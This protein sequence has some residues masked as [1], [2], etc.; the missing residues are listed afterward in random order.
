M[1]TETKAKPAAKPSAKPAAKPSAK[2]AAKPSAKPAA[3][4]KAAKAKKSETPPVGIH[5]PVMGLAIARELAPAKAN[6]ATGS[7]GEQDHLRVSASE[8]R[9]ISS[10]AEMVVYFQGQ[11]DR[12]QFS[13]PL[14]WARTY[15][16]AAARGEFET[17]HITRRNGQVILE[18]LDSAG[19][20]KGSFAHADVTIDY[21]NARQATAKRMAGFEFGGA[22]AY[23]SRLLAMLAHHRGRVG[24][25]GPIIFIS[26]LSPASPTLF[27][28]QGDGHE[29]LVG[30]QASPISEA[31]MQLARKASLLCPTWEAPEPVSGPTKTIP[32]LVEECRKAVEDGDKTAWDKLSRQ[33][34][35]R[36]G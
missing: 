26:G 17:L 14:A 9:G 8:V 25:H 2:P 15:F 31:D 24:G 29:A 35:A 34:Q 13:V 30:S 33:L 12:Q 20:V 10:K 11:G 3:K 1:M 6:Q 36:E 28:W 16:D 18:G 4:P 22:T 21:T 19:L 7:G 32:Q 27:F 5:T 23:D